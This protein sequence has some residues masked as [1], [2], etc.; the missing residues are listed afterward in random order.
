M[1]NRYFTECKGCYIYIDKHG[2]PVGKPN[3]KCSK[4][5]GE[6]R[7]DASGELDYVKCNRCNGTGVSR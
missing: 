2:D 5:K 6:G 4:C 7:Y 1:D 3:G